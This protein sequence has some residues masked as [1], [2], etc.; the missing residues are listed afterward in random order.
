EKRSE[1]RPA[2]S[3][4]GWGL[5]AVAGV[6]AAVLGFG[7][8]RASQPIPRTLVRHEVDLGPTVSFSAQPDLPDM[9]LSPDGTRLV[10]V[11]GIPSKLYLLRLDQPKAKAVELSG[12]QGTES[13]PFF[14]QDGQW[15]GF[16]IGRKLNK[17]SVEGGAVVPLTD[18]PN[19][20]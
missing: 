10:F 7:L 19:G 11:S 5:A 2:Q 3:R 17:I 16:A 18:L 14:S 12:T 13:G 15:V 4:L 1:D 9:T 6:I 8:W 20:F